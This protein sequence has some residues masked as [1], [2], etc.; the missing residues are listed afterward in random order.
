[1]SAR[2]TR[3]W[4]RTFASARGSRNFRLFLTGQFISAIGTWMTFTTTSWLILTLPTGSAAA[5]GINAALAFGPVLL[6]GPW[7]GVLADRFDKR[8]ILTFT[9]GTAAIISL[10]LATIVFTD[11]VSLWMVFALSLASGIVTS[12]DNPARQSFYVEMVGEG[13]LTNAVSLNSAAFTGARIIG[14]AVAGILIATVGMA[15]CFLI[16]GIS[17]LAVVT[18]L[19]AM[20]TAE[21]HL[22]RR[23][24]RERGHLVAGLRYVWETDALRRPLVVMAIVFTFVFEWQVLVPLLANRTFHAGPRAF[25]LLSAA[26]GLGSFI[27]AILA[28]NRNSRPSMHGLGVWLVA[29]GVTMALVSVAPTLPVAIVLMVPIGFFAMSFMITGNTMLQLEAKPQA[30]GRVMALYGVVF[31]GSTPIGAPLVGWLAG[32]LGARLMFLAAGVLAVAVAVVVLWSRTG[33]RVAR[34]DPTVEPV[35]ALD[36]PEAATA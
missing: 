24:T 13:T 7:G 6:L 9:Q 17:Y 22:Q 3:A 36:G 31:L 23:S 34:E 33:S 25:G 12:L 15:I 20:R 30:R 35:A 32:I 27:G 11:V 2:I 5:L 19:L 26:A 29:V 14:P 10:T 8:R 16:D 28:A 18:A 4:D 1:M 21:M